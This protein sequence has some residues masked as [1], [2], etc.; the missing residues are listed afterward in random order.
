MFSLQLPPRPLH[1]QLFLR[2]VARPFAGGGKFGSDSSDLVTPVRAEPVA[3]ADQ[4]QTVGHVTDVR[5]CH[6]GRLQKY[7]HVSFS[8]FFVTFKLK[9]SFFAD[10]LKMRNIIYSDKTNV[11][12]Q[13][14][15]QIC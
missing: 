2:D 13:S 10:E 8:S 12:W 1:C 14:I 9:G 11:Q 3:A 7:E 6:V 4:Q 15:V 5:V